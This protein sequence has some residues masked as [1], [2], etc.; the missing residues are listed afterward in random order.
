VRAYMKLD[1]AWAA[2]LT[3]S[4]GSCWPGEER[5]G[6]AIGS[7]AAAESSQRAQRVAQSLKVKDTICWGVARSYTVGQGSVQ[8]H[9]VCQCQTL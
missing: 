8:H 6:G 5:D 9:N 7:S 3:T 4:S 2:L 1:W